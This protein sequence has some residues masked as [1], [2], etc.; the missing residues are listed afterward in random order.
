MKVRLVKFWRGH[1]PG[2]VLDLERG[3][4]DAYVNVARVAVWVEAEVEAAPPEE[5]PA[6]K[7]VEHMVPHLS[8][9]RTTKAKK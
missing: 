9:A 4:A 7:P 1:L 2:E 6:L 8:G 3:V 5:K